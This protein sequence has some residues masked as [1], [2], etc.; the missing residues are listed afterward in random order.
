MNKLQIFANNFKTYS[1]IVTLQNIYKN[2]YLQ[3][4]L[5]IQ[6]RYLLNNK[7]YISWIVKKFTKK[8]Y[9]LNIYLLS[10]LLVFKN[11]LN[12]L[13]SQNFFIKFIYFLNNITKVLNH[14]LIDLGYL[15][16][17]IVRMNYFIRMVNYVIN[18]ILC[19]TLF[20]YLWINLYIALCD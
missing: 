17:D 18:Y 14:I 16:V 20:P 2:R 15:N 10:L 4:Q 13:I 19:A 6:F 12:C 9:S 8:I 3:S 5:H 1:K 11:I 7:V